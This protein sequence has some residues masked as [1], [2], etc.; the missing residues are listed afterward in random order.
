MNKP[1]ALKKGDTVQIVA[2][3]GPVNEDAVHLMKQY[4]MHLGLDVQLGRHIFGKDGFLAGSDAQRLEDLQQAITN[5]DVKA[6]FCARGG[7]GSA[8]LLPYLDITPLI[9][10]PKIFWGYSDITYLHIIMN[11]HARMISFHGPMTDGYGTMDVH[12]HSLSSLQQLFFPT[13]ILFYAKQ[14]EYPSFSHT[15]RAP[16]VGGNVTVLV[17]TLG[18]PYEIDTTGRILML[19]DIDEAPYAIDRMLNQLRLAGKLQNCAGIILADF[20]DCEPKKGKESLSLTRIVYDHIVPNQVPILAGFP[21]GHCRPNYAIPIGGYAVMN[22][23]E[24][25]LLLEPGIVSTY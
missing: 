2:P 11:Q 5:P 23:T 1:P 14:D 3:A 13:P 17:S 15:V 8:R 18:T 12:P 9:S 22:G 16:I 19:E 7:Y 10:Q 25:T 20:H 24:R 21:I 4:L 6:I